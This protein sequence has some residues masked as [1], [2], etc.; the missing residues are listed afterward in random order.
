MEEAFPLIAVVD[1]DE[2]VRKALSRLLR[3]CKY[4]VRSFA[5]GGEFLDSLRES[6]PDCLVLDL[7]MP[8]I[9]GLELLKEL[10]AR[11]L[12]VPVIIITAHDE[13]TVRASC[14]AAGASKYLCKPIDEVVLRRAITEAI[15]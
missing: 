11:G 8:E 7:Q 13:P 9:N 12:S 5:S 1:D 15:H 3:I 6:H 4:R 10:R 14:L 2:P